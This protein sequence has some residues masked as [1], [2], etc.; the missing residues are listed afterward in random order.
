MPA[1]VVAAVEANR[2]QAVQPLHAPGE[3]GLRRLDQE[4][5][6][7]VEEAPDVN[8]PAEA[9]FDFDEQ[10]EPGLAVEVVEDDPPLLDAA[11]DDVVPG[12]ARKLR[13]GNPWHPSRLAR[14]DRERNRRK[15]TCPR[16]SPWDTSLAALRLSVTAC[17]S[18]FRADCG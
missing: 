15:G 5:E 17:A 11:A 4:V 7:V 3:L 1:A 8:P 9:L 16:D 18:R 12:R 10:L 13:A 14:R 6:V 2:V